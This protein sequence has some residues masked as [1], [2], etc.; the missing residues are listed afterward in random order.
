M[1]AEQ[2]AIG[3]WGRLVPEVVGMIEE[4]L[5]RSGGVLVA[6]VQ[7]AVGQEALGRQQVEGFVAADGRARVARMST[8]KA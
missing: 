2:P 3:R 6:E 1:G 4:C 8:E 7:I 5:V